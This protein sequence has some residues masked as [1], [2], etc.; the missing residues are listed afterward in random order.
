MIISGFMFLPANSTKFV[1]VLNGKSQAAYVPQYYAPSAG[2]VG[3]PFSSLQ[4]NG[5]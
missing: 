1:T 2:S 4:Q 5:S 3:Q